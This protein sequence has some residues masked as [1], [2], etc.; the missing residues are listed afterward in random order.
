MEIK[1][2]FSA[3][4]VFGEIK[5]TTDLVPSHTTKV[6]YHWT[7]C[8]WKSSL[9]H[10]QTFEKHHLPNSFKKTFS[11]WKF[12][13]AGSD[14][15]SVCL[16]Q[17]KIFFICIRNVITRTRQKLEHRLCTSLAQWVPAPIGCLGDT[18]ISWLS[19]KTPM[20]PSWNSKGWGSCVWL[21]H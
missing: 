5:W 21:T 14:S 16:R 18:S 15:Y 11:R 13:T 6:T 10:L 2:L 1:F 20:K 4:Q 12:S 3:F 7:K 19:I 17:Y 8:H 9:T